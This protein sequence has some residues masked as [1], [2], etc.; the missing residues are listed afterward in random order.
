[1]FLLLNQCC[2]TR[3]TNERAY[4]ELHT[5]SPFDLS[6][7][8]P[9]KH[10]YYSIVH[11]QKVQRT[12]TDETSRTPYIR[13]IT[14]EKSKVGSF[15]L[16]V[17]FCLLEANTVTVWCVVRVH[18]SPHRLDESLLTGSRTYEWHCKSVRTRGSSRS[19]QECLARWTTPV[20]QS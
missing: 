3:V 5:I 15:L 10:T 8:G 17:H 14:D 20:N 9:W 6:Y 11:S 7:V 4:G 19:R 2:Y 16:G 13:T 12:N 1:M 18:H